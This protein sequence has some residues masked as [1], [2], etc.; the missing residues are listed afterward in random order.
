MRP[1]ASLCRCWRSAWACWARRCCAGTPSRAPVARQWQQK[2][3]AGCPSQMPGDLYSP[4]KS[5]LRPHRLEGN[6]NPSVTKLKIW[7]LELMRLYPNL[8]S[9]DLGPTYVENLLDRLGAGLLGSGSWQ[10]VQPPLQIVC[11]LRCSSAAA[12]L[13]VRLQRGCPLSRAPGAASPHAVIAA[14]PAVPAP[15][16]R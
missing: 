15:Q 3:C 5:S 12:P 14:H 6:Y 9:M 1:A 11:H 8:P 13:D 10:L 7:G 4:P 2:R 16:S